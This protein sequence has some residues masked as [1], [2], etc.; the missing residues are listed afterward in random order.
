VYSRI[1]NPDAV[2]YDPVKDL[3]P[4]G[5]H[6]WNPMILVVKQDSPWKTFPEFVDYAK[7]NPGKV[8][9]SLLGAMA[10]ERFNMEIIKSLTDAQVNIIPFKGPSEALGAILGGHVES[11]FIGIGLALPQVKAGKIKPLLTTRK[12]SELPD[13]P[14]LIELG[15]KKELDSGWFA[16]YAPAGV[17]EEVKMA[18]VPAFEKV[19][20]NPEMKSRIDKMG[21]V[22]DYKSPAELKKIMIESFETAMSIAQKIGGQK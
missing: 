12:W 16:F 21:F 6:V 2:P 7:K 4:I 17:P 1:P 8:T 13:V 5:L 3:E 14:T 20:R 9:M 11:S 10:I 15:Y 22:V 19:A 18:L